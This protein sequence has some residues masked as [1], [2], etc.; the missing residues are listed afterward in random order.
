[1]ASYERFDVVVVGAGAAGVAAALAAAKSGMRVALVDAGPGVG[2][3]LV[4]GLPIDACVNPRGEWIVGGAPRQLFEACAKLGGYIGPVADGR[5]MYAVCFDPELMRLAIIDELAR[6]GVV[7]RLYSPVTDVVHDDEGRVEAVICLARGRS[8]V[9]AASTFI[10][11]SGDG[12]VAVMAGASSEHGG[13]NG[14]LQPVSLIYRVANVDF[15]AYLTFL[16]DHPEEFLLAESPAFSD[17]PAQCAQIVYDAG[18]PHMALSAGGS[19]LG[20]AIERGEMFPSTFIFTWPTSVARREVGV[21]TTRVAGV[22]G[23]RS[24]D[25]S[26]A[27]SQ[28]GGQ[29][30]TS[31]RF[32]RNYLPG[33]AD[34]QLS[35]LAPRVG[36]RETRR[37][38]GEA[39]LDVDDVLQA[40]KR[41]DGVAKG[42][43]HV[44]VHGS[45]TAQQRVP[46]AGG[47]SYDIPYGCL[48]PRG[49]SN[50]LMAGRCLSSTREAN[51]SARVMGTC[52][53][54]GQAAGL[55]AAETVAR[56]LP[57]VRELPVQD[58]R[59]RLR[60]TG[61]VIDGTA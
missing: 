55:A 25:L 58:L 47:G 7:L 4:S 29:V 56:S 28:L 6:A 23:V 10:D 16:R 24:R 22:D 52:M 19:L 30:S 18:L 15:D 13:D 38:V 34:A 3:E 20:G 59:A 21:N 27:L 32:C 39:T 60:E 8:T 35:G 41:D 48:I 57:D 50:V 45:G 5:L 17:S 61:A 12:D 11:C 43:H 14:A 9:L 2:G 1:V 54:T 42:C 26:A 31:L 46:V 49:L 36:I 33:F 37:I 51:G 44:D 53:A 40:K